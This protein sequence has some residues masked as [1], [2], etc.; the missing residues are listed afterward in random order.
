MKTTFTSIKTAFV[1]LFFL[2]ASCLPAQNPL[3]GKKVL[4]F[5]KTAG[6]RHSSIP[7]GQK[8]LF[9][10]AKEHGFTVDTTEN[11]NAFTEE[12]L[13]NY[14]LVIFLNT[15]GTVL[16]EMSQKVAFERFIQ[17]GG[18]YVGIHAATDTEYSWD[19][20]SKLS[21][22]QF[23]S[24]PGNPN[25]QA[26]RHIVVDK[27]HP[28]T[29]FM[30]NEFTRTDEF[31]DFKKFNPAVNVLIKID[32]KTY[33][34]GKMGDDHPMSWY[35]EFDGGRAFYMNW[36][37][38]HESFSEPTVIKHLWGGMT[39]ATSGGDMNY[40]KARSQLPPEENRFTRTILDAKLDEPTE[41][42]VTDDGTIFYVERKGKVKM[43]NQKTGTV[44]QIAQIPVYSQFE[45]GLMG[46]NIDPN[47]NQ[48]KWV[49]LFY[50][51]LSTEADTAQRLSRFVYDAA[52]EELDLTT[53][54]I[55]L[56]VPVKRTDCC[57]TGGSI[58][59]DK[60]GN[61]Y[62]ST[63][64]D[65]N[66]FASDGYG[67]MDERPGRQ[68]WDG[69][70][71]SSNTNDLRGKIL[72]IKPT[73]EGAYTI[74]DGNLFPKGTDKA[75]P[76]IYVMG[77]RNPYRIA[78]DKRTG[79]LYWGEVGPDAGENSAKY[80]PRGHD[81]VNQARRAGYFGWPLFVADNRAYFERRFADTTFQGKRFNP[82]KPINESPHNTGL[83]E[84]PPAQK[85]FIYYPYAD[86][87]EFG[88]VVGK[89]GRNAM[90][91]PVYYADD[92]KGV[93]NRFPDYYNGKFFAYDWMRDWVNVVTMTPQGDFM[94]MERF[95][96]NTT[97]SHP[98]DMQFGKDGALY[99]LEYGP[100][101][102]AQNDD[103]RLTKI[104]YNP[105]N[106]KPVAVAKASKMAGAAPMTVQFSSADSK[107]FDGDPLSI[108]W[109]FDGKK[110]S[111][112]PN[113]SF[114]F[115]KAGIYKPTLTVKD[116]KGNISTHTLEVR[117]GNE[118]PSVEMA[119][120][121]NRS[122]YWN[123]KPINYEVK[124]SD[125]EDGSLAAKTIS[126]EDVNLR[127]DYLQGYDKTLIAQGHQQAPKPSGMRLIELSDCKSCHA[128][129][130]KSIGPSYLQIAQKYK[131]VGRATTDL[132][133]KIVNGGGGVWGEQA[134]AAHPQI[135]VT[136]ATEMAKY[137]LSLADEKK[138]GQ[139]L[140]GSYTPDDKGKPGTYILSTTYSDKG[141]PIVGTQTVSSTVILRN[142]KFKAAAFDYQHKTMS[143]KVEPMGDIV[144]A[145]EH[146]S[147]IGFDA[148]DLTGLAAIA[149]TATASD[150]RIAG[151]MMEIHLD[152]PTG[153][154]LGSAEV[155]PGGG[156]PM[157]QRIPFK[158][159]Q[160]GLHKLYIV[161]TNPN[162]A[163]KPVMV[164]LDIAVE[165]E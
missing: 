69:R 38:T 53:E 42:V 145:T 118:P 19:W 95:L 15:T 155:K 32:E 92:F 146:G 147:Y 159:K 60:D 43:F 17:A 21:G 3:T 164:L 7:Y 153:P 47:F 54:K 24:H 138:K 131:G 31:Y 125:K 65:V 46:I 112:Q 84:L 133:S 116:S 120:K 89:G 137:I 130:D 56:R 160:T 117:V 55:L 50:S 23:A 76:E 148:I 142:A 37:H 80:G 110:K 59:W 94:G 78:V 1:L 81:E 96:P 4:V 151:G 27:N 124:V 93:P 144:I 98:M 100:N 122:F 149:V 13:K 140:S 20:Y 52:K 86:S 134:M 28:A 90:A 66:P 106:R 36:G 102:F 139:P 9:A 25:V 91:G 2:S 115:K 73:A 63:G 103:A 136:D 162:A 68:G 44:K 14:R 35:H 104:E 114:T 83:T 101:W 33:K 12:N 48:N 109:V 128:L 71:S 121:G 8:C 152:S 57:H 49:Y 39:W 141:D 157:P 132:A 30:D 40:A 34:E 61:L 158:E 113:P 99:M 85:A 74:P 18:A 165:A 82:N 62:L 10:L 156:F 72:R 126:E 88:E 150:A 97:F 111:K 5:S 70:H 64:D 143:L 108:A 26:G 154:L 45:Y 29:S 11:A 41:L 105:G 127:I 107:D 87:P 163:P 16:P 135:S 79:Y 58:D 161:C 67:P 51:P 75:R 22:G 119:I 77:T 123:K 129:K 6:F